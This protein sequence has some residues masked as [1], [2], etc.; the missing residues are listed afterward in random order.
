M[1]NYWTDETEEALAKYVTTEDMDEK[2]KI[3]NDYLFIP[4]R[5]LIDVLLERYCIPIVDDDI[6]LDILT[7]V[8]EYMGRFNPEAVY[9]SG[10]KASGKSYCIILVRSWFADYKLKYARQKK[11]IQFEACHE[12][13][14]NKNK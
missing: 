11:I 3:F 2:N 12:I 9:P 13:H 4:L 8:V 14:L 10:K 1:E 7:H 5:K 6:K